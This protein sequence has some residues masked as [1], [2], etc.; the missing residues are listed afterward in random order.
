M[1]QIDPPVTRDAHATRLNR[2]STLP[3]DTRWR[4]SDLSPV[5]HDRS[6]VV[7]GRKQNGAKGAIRSWIEMRPEGLARKSQ[8]AGAKI[9]YDDLHF[10]RIG[11]A[12]QRDN[13]IADDSDRQCRGGRHPETPAG[14]ELDGLN[15]VTR[16]AKEGP[17]RTLIDHSCGKLSHGRT[18]ANCMALDHG[19]EKR[20]ENG[21]PT[22][23]VYLRSLDPSSRFGNRSRQTDNFGIK[24]TIL[25]SNR[26]PLSRTR[27]PGHLCA[28]I[29]SQFEHKDGAVT[30]VVCGR[31]DPPESSA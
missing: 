14:L 8:R 20:G 10:A 3:S 9:E 12:S 27:Q 31:A 7:G 11:R 4:R 25:A 15:R 24:G 5:N 16:C 26:R 13:A 19:R 21:K 29:R 18:P 28:Y 17:S 6:I 2:G 30:I 23:D 22:H 1:R